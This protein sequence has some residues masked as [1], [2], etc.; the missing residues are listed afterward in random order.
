EVRHSVRIINSLVDFATGIDPATTRLDLNT[1]IQTALD[2]APVPEGVVIEYALAPD[3]P[4]II[5]DESQLLQVVEHL[6][7]NAVQAM[8]GEGRLRIST[9][10][11]SEG[12]WARF[13]D[14]GP[15]VL[16]EDQN[17]IF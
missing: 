9:G 16:A 2:Y 14:S 1:L 12:V 7:R 3:L 8:E 5:A 4:S 6:V 15:G 17:R 10:T 13:Q 11:G